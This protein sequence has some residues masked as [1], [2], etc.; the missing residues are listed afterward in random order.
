MTDD[1]PDLTYSLH[2]ATPDNKFFSI[3]NGVGSPGAPGY[4]QITVGSLPKTGSVDTDPVLDYET[5]PE[6]TVQIQV[7]DQANPPQRSSFSVPI[8]LIN[9]NEVP[10]FDENS[11]GKTALNYQETSTGTVAQYTAIDPDDPRNDAAVVWYVTGPDADDFEIVDGALRF[12]ES[13]DPEWPRLREPDGPEF[14]WQPQ[15]LPR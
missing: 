4:P 12:V 6:F 15:R 9:L 10:F 2:T 14:R 1:N 3:T 7:A 8:G 5:D 13:L 11:K